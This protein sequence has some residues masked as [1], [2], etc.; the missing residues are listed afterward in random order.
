MEKNSI[1]IGRFLGKLEKS[2]K[3]VGKNEDERMYFNFLIVKRKSNSYDRIPI[4][5]KE[6][7][8]PRINSDNDGMDKVYING[9]IIAN[10]I[11]GK[12]M[13]FVYV[14]G[15]I[16]FVPNASNDI[17]NVTINGRIC[18]KPRL[19]ALSHGR[20]ICDFML[21]SFSE[22]NKR[23]Y[24]P[25]ICWDEI[26]GRISNCKIGNKLNISAR[27]QSRRFSKRENDG[28]VIEKEAYE[29][30]IIKLKSIYIKGS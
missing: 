25:I 20:F 28:S 3:F 10:T 14:L 17:N 2:F 13:M 18:S 11:D 24:T 15:P 27:F 9:E 1:N 4:V 29:L 12:H 6:E 26:A 7:F 8:L 22:E 30:S 21:C 16:V 23:I 5:V 19:Q